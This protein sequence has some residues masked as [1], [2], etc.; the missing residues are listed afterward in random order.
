MSDLSIDEIIKRAEEIKAEAEQHLIEAERSLQE[1]AKNAIEDVVVDEKKVLERIARVSAMAEE[2]DDIK[3]FKPAKKSSSIFNKAKRI[4]D[5]EEEDI[6]IAKDYSSKNKNTEPTQEDDSDMK[7]VNDGKTGVVD[8]AKTRSVKLKRSKREKEERTRQIFVSKTEIDSDSDLESIPTIVAKEELF[9]KEQNNLE[10]DIGIQMTFDGFDDKIEAIP[11]I[12]EDLAEQIL[13]ERRKDK[14]DKFRLFGPDETDTELGNENIVDEDYENENEKA[15][16]INALEKKKRTLN[17]KLGITTVIGGLLIALAW[18]FDKPFA[19]SFLISHYV[20]FITALVLYVGAIITNFNVII[21]GFNFKRGINSDFPIAIA[22][23]ILLGHTVALTF[24]QSLCIDNGV[25]LAPL[26]A[27][28]LFL[29]QLGKRQMMIR[30]IDNFKFISDK[31]DKYTVENIVNKVD[32]Q[33]ITRDLIE[34]EPIVKTSV[35]TDFPTNFLEISCKA[36]PSDKVSKIIFLASIGAS[37]VLFFVIGLI[38]NFNT[39][40]NTAISALAITVPASAIFMTNA[41]LSS[42]SKALSKFGSVVCG[43]EGARMADNA[44]AMV[45]EAADLFTKGNCVLHGI[46]TFNKAKPDDAIIKAAAVMTQTKSPLASVFDDVIIGKQRILPPIDDVLYEDKMGTSAWIYDRKVLV[47]NRTL[48][49][50]HNIKLPKKSVEEKYT[51]DDRKALYLSVDGELTAMFIV[52]YKAEPNLK[53]E[54]KRLEKSGI[55]IIVKSCD[56]YINE[57]S[58]AKLFGLPEGYISVMN[59]SASRVYD[60]Y[61]GMEVEKSPAYVVHNGTALGFVSAMHAA[62]KIVSSYHLLTFLESFGSALGYLAV[63]LL[64]VIG[65]YGELTATNIMAY[66]VVWSLFM[67]IIAKIRGKRI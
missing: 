22:S 34:G 33:I 13:K 31:N 14:V 46:K 67:M 57:K 59:P 30:I 28:S 66:Q 63:A 12:D 23:I 45:M 52:S 29:S 20:Y 17:I 47:G 39:G 11:T 3:Q 65:S 48:L 64:S 55:Q 43:V 37:L 35:K 4:D 56:P 44:N 25:L 41:M 42:I 8:L 2:E 7:L 15:D 40:F 19:P 36:E 26:G 50:N 24:S 58:L 62:E 53:R 32:A 16:F 60:K 10:E 5:E 54:L 61:S 38:D 6:K 9:E 21:H 49:E 18:I 27:F 1:K 51:T